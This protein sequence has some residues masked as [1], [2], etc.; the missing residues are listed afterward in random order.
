MD[1]LID[2]VFIFPG[3]GNLFVIFLLLFL[4]IGVLLRID[5]SCSIGKQ[6]A[7]KKQQFENVQDQGFIPERVFKRPKNVPDGLRL[8]TSTWLSISPTVYLLMKIKLDRCMTW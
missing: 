3:V 2:H 4:V 5:Y 1:W 8:N 6:I 7:Q